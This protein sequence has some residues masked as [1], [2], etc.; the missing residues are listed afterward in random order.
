MW[1]R[2]SPGILLDL[3]KSI[4]DMVDETR[5]FHTGS[6]FTGT[7]VDKVSF[8]QAVAGA[9]QQR[10]GKQINVIEQYVVEP[11][12]PQRDFLMANHKGCKHF[13]NVAADLA[14]T[15]AHC[16]KTGKV[17]VIPFVHYLRWGFV[18]CSVSPAI[19]HAKGN[20]GCTSRGEGKTGESFQ[21][22][23]LVVRRHKPP[24]M[25]IEHL[26]ELNIAKNKDNK[27]DATDL[28]YVIRMI[29][30]EGYWIKEFTVEAYDY[31]SKTMR[32]RLL[33]GCVLEETRSRSREA[34]MRN[35]LNAIKLIPPFNPRV[36]DQEARGA[37]Q[38]TCEETESYH[39]TS[40]SR[41]PRDA[42]LD[43]GLV[44][45][46]RAGRIEQTHWAH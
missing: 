40:I 7:G 42:F 36:L 13:F 15:T 32:K 25:T 20:R 37:R 33:F 19:N 21:E 8:K 24:Y 16:A 10:F 6:M 46:T 4:D 5:S 30:A 18:C 28:E 31:S 1:D 39:R 26:K 35:V 29:E 27:N 22:G 3:S 17:V 12:L 41:R 45:A 14:N 38:G 11:G 34:Y 44:L 23:L 43:A 2:L 9:Y